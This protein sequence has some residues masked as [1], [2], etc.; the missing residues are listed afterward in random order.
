MLTFLPVQTFCLCPTTVATLTTLLPTQRH[1]YTHITLLAFSSGNINKRVS[2]GTALIIVFIMQI[3]FNNTIISPSLL[4]VTLTESVGD[5]SYIIRRKEAGAAA[6]VEQKTLWTR[7]VSLP[8]LL[9]VNK[10]RFGGMK[11]VGGRV[12]EEGWLS[13]KTANS[14]FTCRFSTCFHISEL[15]TLWMATSFHQM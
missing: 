9:H 7:A 3:T 6:P 15:C 1:T 11:W 5:G 12:S 4:I 2:S 14:Y 8:M 10:L 13:V